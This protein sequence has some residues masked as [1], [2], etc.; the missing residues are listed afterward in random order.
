MFFMKNAKLVQIRNVKI[1][2]SYW[3]HSKKKHI[4][5]VVPYSDFVHYQVLSTDAKDRFDVA[6]MKPNKTK[7]LY[8]IDKKHVTSIGTIDL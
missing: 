8:L 6:E 2:S 1:K 5:A 4:Y 7:T 3:Y